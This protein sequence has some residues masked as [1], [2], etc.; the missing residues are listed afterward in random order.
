[1]NNLAVSGGVMACS[2]TLGFGVSGKLRG[3]IG[4]S[5]H[6]V[7]LGS[8]NE[9][10]LRP[11][12]APYQYVG[13]AEKIKRTL[14]HV[15][16][17]EISMS[18]IF[19]AES[20]GV[21]LSECG[22]SIDNMKDFQNVEATLNDNGVFV[23]RTP[24][25][26]V[27][28]LEQ[29]PGLKWENLKPRDL[30]KVEV[31][32]LTDRDITSLNVR[33][34]EGLTNLAELS[35]QGNP[36]TSLPQGL[37]QVLPN[38]R[39]V[40]IALTDIKELPEDMLT[41][42]VPNL[43]ILKLNTPQQEC[44]ILPL[45]KINPDLLFFVEPS[46][47]S[48]DSVKDFPNVEVSLNDN[49]VFV[50]R[51]PAIK[52]AILD[53]LPGLEWENLS[54]SDL[55]KI[56]KLDLSDREITSLNVRD[57]EGLTH[58]VYLQLSNNPIKEFPEGLFAAIPNLKE[59]SMVFTDIQ[60]LSHEFK[61]TV[62]PQLKSIVLD[63]SQSGFSSILHDINSEM[64][65]M[66]SRCDKSICGSAPKVDL[67][68]PVVK[69]II[70]DQLKDVGWEQLDKA[71]E[72]LRQIHSIDL[73]FQN[74]KSLSVEDLRGLDNLAELSLQNNPLTSLPEGLSQ[75]L[76]NLRYLSI[77]AT[78]IKDLPEDMLTHTVPNLKILKL[79]SSQEEFFLPLSKI[80]P[81]LLFHIEPGRNML[82][83]T[84]LFRRTVFSDEKLSGVHAESDLKQIRYL[85]LSE[86]YL[87]GLYEDDLKGFDNLEELVLSNNPIEE[88]PE[89]F[90]ANVPNLKSL[91]IGFTKI[92]KLSE[93]M[94]TDVIPNLDGID[95]DADQSAV[96]LNVLKEINPDL[97][98]F[99][100]R[101]SPT[102]CGN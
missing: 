64:T 38:L 66:I 45:S 36:L 20:K 6:C 74:L 30:S 87:K 62:A 102:T 60:E 22:H 44:L 89:G 54:P 42:T 39:Y 84:R 53:Q 61:T 16:Q 96:M 32:D 63:I 83:K 31:L 37:S 18:K 47:Y 33:D 92:L 67:R 90:F 3:T 81:S 71:Q 56:E 76:P 28:I 94:K 14:S 100:S 27:A 82:S 13:S 95:I 52:A 35:L 88:I 75:V 23:D 2:G 77:A 55:S 97:H 9:P 68:N 85:D 41:H 10:K 65:I 5:V 24:A 79:D 72:H 59:L 57:F 26:K 50:D 58:L 4:S 12:L 34:F 48:T 40:T 7:N 17:S 80:N 86:K 51:T 21:D 49:G 69:R 98:I 73:G 11:S 1:M 19:E 101:C 93:E 78:D 91:S 29:L 8:L 15:P 70:L 99:V 25:I 46:R 43:K